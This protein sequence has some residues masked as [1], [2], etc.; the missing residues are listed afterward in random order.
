MRIR[1]LVIPFAAAALVLA[2]CSSQGEPSAPSPNAEPP[3]AQG[4]NCSFNE[5]KD[6][7]TAVQEPGQAP[8]LTVSSDAKVPKDLVVV[9]LCEGEGTASKPSDMVTVDYIGVGYKTQQ[10]FDSSLERGE[11]ATFPLQG[12]IEGWT[13][14]VSG[15]KPGGAVLLL[16][17]S[18]LAYRERGN[19][20]VILQNEALAFIVEVLAVN[21]SE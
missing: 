21:P 15:V 13:R 7:V 1:S 17:P 14:G 19:P 5:T 10:V 12:V 20:P 8:E 4:F 18:E 9:P 16:V 3:S 2:A 11:P 6:G